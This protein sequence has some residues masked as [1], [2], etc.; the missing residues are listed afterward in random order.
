MLISSWL[1]LSCDS[2]F[3]CAFTA[4]VFVFKVITLVG[5]SQRNYFENANAY[6]KRT[7]KTTVATQLKAQLT[8]ANSVLKLRIFEPTSP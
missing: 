8:H 5:L 7:L 2:R 4:C 1:N 3:Q 6:S